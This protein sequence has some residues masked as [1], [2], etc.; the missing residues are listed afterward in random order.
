MVIQVNINGTDYEADI[1]Y[2]DVVAL[3]IPYGTVYV[4]SKGKIVPTKA[5][6]NYYCR[7]INKEKGMTN[8]VGQ[9]HVNYPNGKEDFRHSVYYL[10]PNKKSGSL[11]FGNF[12]YD[13]FLPYQQ[14]LQTEGFQQAY[15]WMGN[16]RK[17]GTYYAEAKY[18]EEKNM[19]TITA[20]I[21]KANDKKNEI[22]L[23][24]D[25]KVTC[26][27]GTKEDKSWWKYDQ[28]TKSLVTN[29]NA[30]DLMENCQNNNEQLNPSLLDIAEEVFPEISCK[31]DNYGY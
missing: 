21:K 4:R 13:K 31:F 6:C 28:K 5:Y 2:G 19:L 14:I 8:I 30:I 18:S 12:V 9:I 7:S 20:G 22:E 27:A 16:E 3:D 11:N 29:L 24:R 23:Q 25:I 26:N 15:A 1:L 17:I 10:K